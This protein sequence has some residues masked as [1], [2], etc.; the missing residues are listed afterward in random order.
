MSEAAP[1]PVELDESKLNS[2]KCS[3]L[4]AEREYT[5][6]RSKTKDEMVELIRKT[7][8]SIADRTY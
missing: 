4:R 7:I 2:M 8:V 1:T 6:T 5:S 3:I